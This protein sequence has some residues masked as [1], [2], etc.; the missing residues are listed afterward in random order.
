MYCDL[1][2]AEHSCLMAM[3]VIHAN[4]TVSSG[5]S[6]D[7]SGGFVCVL[8]GSGRGNEALSSPSRLA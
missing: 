1:G 4:P 2:W 8:N 5:N 6:T 7:C 3:S